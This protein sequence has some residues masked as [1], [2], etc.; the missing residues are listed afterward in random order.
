MPR[1]FRFGEYDKKITKMLRENGYFT[2]RRSK[3][4]HNIEQEPHL[5][6]FGADKARQYDKMAA[7]LGRPVGRDE[8]DHIKGGD[9]GRCDC[10]HNLQFLSK[11]SHDAKHNREIKSAKGDQ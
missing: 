6:L 8:L 3:V 11:K 10:Q 2:D 7:K 5:K 9:W 1:G 4:V